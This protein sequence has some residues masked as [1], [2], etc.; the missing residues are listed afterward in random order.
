MRH[1]W[2]RGGKNS[3]YDFEMSDRT[4][5]EGQYAV[6]SLAGSQNLCQTINTRFLIVVSAINL[7]LR[8]KNS[9]RSDF[10]SWVCGMFRLHVESQKWKWDFPKSLLS[11]RGL[12]ASVIHIFP[13]IIMMRN[14]SIKPNLCSGQRKPKGISIHSTIYRYINSGVETPYKEL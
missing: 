4:G 8:D 9:G 2:E 10:A 1:P 11:R 5:P 7:C 3:Q 6:L 13:F 14:I 12:Y